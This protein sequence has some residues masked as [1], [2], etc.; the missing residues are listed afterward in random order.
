MR[1][2]LNRLLGDGQKV[3]RSQKIDFA[4]S[5]FPIFHILANRSPMTL[6]EIA[7]AL[8]MAHPSVIEVTDEMIKKGYVESR[9]GREDRRRRHLFLTKKGEKTVARLEPIW[10]AFKQAADEACG[11]YGNDFW[12]SIR[13]IEQALDERSMYER[14]VARLNKENFNF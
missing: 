3:Y 2:L 7:N 9:R 8:G 11:E 12:E 6:T 5:W 1:R 4:V 13:K 14:I 10:E